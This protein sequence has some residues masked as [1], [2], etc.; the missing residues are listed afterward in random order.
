MKS[1]DILKELDTF[2]AN[3]TGLDDPYSEDAWRIYLGKP[4]LQ[5]TF[6]I[7]SYI[8]TKSK[9]NNIIYYSLPNEFKDELFK[10]ISR[11]SFRDC[12]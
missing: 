4:Q 3:Y 9:E 6:S 12:K 10:F 5:N 8:P 1:T 7:S 2:N 11:F